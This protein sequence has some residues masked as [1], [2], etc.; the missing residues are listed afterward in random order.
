MDIKKI[1]VL[2]TGT[3]GH[4][5]AQLC[6]Q[7]GFEVNMYGRS[8][9]SL[10]RGFTNIK[11]DLSIMVSNNK[12]TEE[13]S[14][15]IFSK[16][17]G[18]KTLKEVC[19]GVQLIVECLAEKI[20][21][22]RDIFNQLDSLCSKEVILTSSTSGL[23]PSDIAEETKNPERVVVAHFWNPPQLIPL[24]EVV[25]GCKTSAEVVNKTV[26]WVKNIGKQPVKMNKECPGFIGNR[27]QL[28]LLREALYIVEQGY[29]DPEE[30][31]KA[32]EYSFGRRLPLTGPLKS[33]DL[34]GLDI[35]YNIASY[36][37]KDLCN[38]T[39]P[40]KLLNDRVSEGKL[41]TKKG[42]GIYNWTDE[43]INSIQKKRQELLM[44][45]LDLDK[46]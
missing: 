8:D 32:V 12:I 45:F 20:E 24:V 26:Q 25:P 41:G 10:D 29:A 6:A 14:K 9:E 38:Q 3:M 11:R 23:N 36:L 31:D 46:K 33:A 22:K 40:S 28:A 2:G 7:A 15:I 21:L 18:V 39:E 27:L 35:F 13:E 44:Y 43:E 17:K 37:F 5:V 19:D 30:V 16:I 1:G 4:G 42:A 34:G